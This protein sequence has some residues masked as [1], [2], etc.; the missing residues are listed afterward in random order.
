MNLIFTFILLISIIFTTIISPNAV[1]NAMIEGASKSV[2]LALN[3]LAIYAVWSGFL[4]VAEDSGLCQKLA[5]LLRPLIKKL[6]KP[7]S[8]ITEN[9]IAINLSANMLGMGGIATPSGIEATKHLCDENN[10]DGACLLLIIA[11]TS[12]QLLPT[13][14][15]ALRQNYNSISPFDIFL[16]SLLS[17]IFSTLLAV[18]LYYLT[19]KET[20]Q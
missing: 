2:A 4:Q 8:K 14:V 16:P 19:K 18:C 6:F 20:K 13:T 1:L 10:F 17:T 15:V 9:K 5:K 7:K 12:I 11:S 3:L